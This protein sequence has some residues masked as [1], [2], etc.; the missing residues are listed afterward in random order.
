MDEFSVSHFTGDIP[1]FY[2][3]GLG[4]AMFEGYAADIAG[5]AAADNPSR[6]LETAA[7]TGI[8]TRRL[9]DA[10]PASAEITVTDLNADMLARARAKFS[11]GERVT[12]MSADATDLPFPHQSFDAVVCQFGVMF[13]PDKIRAYREVKRVL[14]G[15]G[16]YLFS[17]WDAHAHNS[18]ARLAHEAV[19]QSHPSDPPPF[20]QVPFGYHHVEVI[21][22]SLREAGFDAIDASIV[23]LESRVPDPAL[24]ARGLI[25]GSPVIEQIRSRPAMDPERLVET[26]TDSLVRELGLP[27]RPLELQAIVFDVR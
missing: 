26:L 23:R 10:L 27:E 7:G 14:R 9:R 13:F 21:R 15:G 11:V 16:R 8:V 19:S 18:F 22:D 20:F 1:D 25:Y 4:H 24:F 3:R 6:L 5:R 17:V 12:F 2:D